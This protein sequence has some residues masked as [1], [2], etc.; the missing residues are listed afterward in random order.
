MRAWLLWV[1][2]VGCLVSSSAAHSEP[3]VDSSESLQRVVLLNNGAV[4]S[5]LLLT[6]DPGREVSLRLADGEVKRFAWSSI[7]RVS[8]VG[9]TALKM[10]RPA[11]HPEA[12]RDT[13]TPR[14]QRKPRSSENDSD[15][16]V[17][18][19][20]PLKLSS[21]LES[22]NISLASAQQHADIVGLRIES[23]VPV[24]LSYVHD[25]ASFD[26]DFLR[27]VMWPVADELAVWRTAC[28]SPCGAWLY[29]NAEYKIKGSEITTASVDFPAR[30]KEFRLT[31]RPGSQVVR[32]LAWSSLVVGAISASVGLALLSVPSDKAGERPSGI[33]EALIGLN[34][35]GVGF[36]L[37]SIPLFI[38]SRTGYR[39]ERID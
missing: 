32:S 38:T 20:S 4:Y 17:H 24:R 6:L 29:R 33:K 22:F 14:E 5:G 1:I 15:A 35:G 7:R 3:I 37:L 26:D 23:P 27:F 10:G 39:L 18:S 16:S 11:Q 19:Y 30:G 34:A 8:E 25:R 12:P 21:Q 2:A 31:I 28:K 13:E 9:E 36:L